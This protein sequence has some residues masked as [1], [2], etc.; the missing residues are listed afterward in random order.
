MHICIWM[1][2]EVQNCRIFILMNIHFL[3]NETHLIQLPNWIQTEST[4]V[5]QA[6][7]QRNPLLRGTAAR[8]WCSGAPIQYTCDRLWQIRIAWADRTHVEAGQE[9]ISFSAYGLRNLAEKNSPTAHFFF[10]NETNSPLSPMHICFI[11][12]GVKQQ[13]TFHPGNCSHYQ[14]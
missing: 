7:C 13:L 9:T 3:W 11:S 12:Y 5:Q 6:L 1:I 10:W 8:P 14:W 2:L 4:C